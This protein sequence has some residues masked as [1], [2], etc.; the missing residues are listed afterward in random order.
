MTELGELLR[1]SAVFQRL[2]A[3]GCARLER[4]AIEETYQPGE[5]IVRQGEAGDAFFAI[6]A[7][8]VAVT[9]EDFGETKQ[10]A[11]LSA[12]TVCGEIAA[13]TREPRTATLTASTVVRVMRF[14]IVSVF[15]VLK[16]YPQVLAELNRLGVEREED[17]L[18]K[19]Q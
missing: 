16:D 2:D 7:G 8:D 12:G 1:K 9:A 19:M 5:Q 17:L 18:Q 6:L 10:V 11:T 15:N 13:L 14:E 3:E 4:I